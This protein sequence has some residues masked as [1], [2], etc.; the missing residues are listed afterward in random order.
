MTSPLKAKEGNIRDF[1]SIEELQ[2]LSNLEVLNSVFISEWLSSQERFNK[3]SKIAIS[4]FES[5]MKLSSINKLKESEALKSFKN[6]NKADY[7]Q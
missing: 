7:N 1:A 4:Q 3:L 5:F 6:L 2:V